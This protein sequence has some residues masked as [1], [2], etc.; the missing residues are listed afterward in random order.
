MSNGTPLISLCMKSPTPTIYS[1]EDHGE[2][3]LINLTGIGSV[4]SS[5]AA[6]SGGQ[7]K[8]KLSQTEGFPI[9]STSENSASATKSLNVKKMPRKLRRNRI[10]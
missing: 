3:S 9:G 1:V 10:L 7:K 8:R 5:S 6:P 2:D 4:G